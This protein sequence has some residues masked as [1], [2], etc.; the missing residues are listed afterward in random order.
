MAATC[1]VQK[2]QNKNP[3]AFHEHTYSVFEFC[4]RFNCINTFSIYFCFEFVFFFLFCG[5]RRNFLRHIFHTMLKSMRNDSQRQCNGTRE[6]FH[7]FIA[8]FVYVCMPE[9]V[10]PI[11]MDPAT[12]YRMQYRKRSSLFACV[13]KIVHGA[14]R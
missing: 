13:R 4:M 5:V 9:H 3:N 12:I 2:K 1:D 7:I 6:E 10:S 8:L 14:V 11:H